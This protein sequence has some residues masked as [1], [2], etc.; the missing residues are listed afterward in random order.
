MGRSRPKEK[1]QHDSPNDTPYSPSDV[2]VFR[3]PF[4]DLFVKGHDEYPRLLSSHESHEALIAS[5]VKESHRLV[6]FSGQRFLAFFVPEALGGTHVHVERCRRHHSRH[7]EHAA[8]RD[9]SV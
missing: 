7:A 5:T 9:G 1:H 8:R 3:L 2:G 6:T 4:Q